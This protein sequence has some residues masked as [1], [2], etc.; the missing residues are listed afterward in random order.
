MIRKKNMVSDARLPG[1]QRY[2]IGIVGNEKKESKY[3]LENFKKGNRRRKSRRWFVASCGRIGRLIFVAVVRAE[4]VHS[5][6]V[7]N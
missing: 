1:E 3:F 2:R 4:G 7:E 5:N 6:A